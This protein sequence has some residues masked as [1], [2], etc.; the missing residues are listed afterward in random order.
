MPDLEDAIVAA[1]EKSKRQKQLSAFENISD[2]SQ[3]N[4][5]DPDG[6]LQL[7]IV[8]GLMWGNRR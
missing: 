6:P 1:L 5:E 7:A 2:L 8:G 4:G 3:T